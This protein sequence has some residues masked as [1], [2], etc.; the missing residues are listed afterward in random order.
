MQVDLVNVHLAAEDNKAADLLQRRPPD[1]G[2][3]GIQTHQW[4]ARLGKGAGR[5]A[6]RVVPVVPDAKHR[7][8][9][10]RRMIEVWTT[11]WI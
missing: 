2:V 8:H 9:R 11:D 6:K 1:T 3:E 4:D 10:P 5:N 7:V